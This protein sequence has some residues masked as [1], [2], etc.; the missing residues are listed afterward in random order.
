MTDTID[1]DKMQSDKI[2]AIHAEHPVQRR[3][4]L[5]SFILSTI[6]AAD[7]LLKMTA[8][9]DQG[10]PVTPDTEDAMDYLERLINDVCMQR[11]GTRIS[12]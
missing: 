8:I 12:K 7:K 9:V 3:R 11:L 6:G 1:Y 4:E 10:C 5:A 2:K